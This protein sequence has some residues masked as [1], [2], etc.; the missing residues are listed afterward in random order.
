MKQIRTRL[1]YANVMSSI[2]V[3]LV[4]GGGAAFAATQLPANS[5]GTKQIKKNAVRT[6][7][8]SFEAIRAG[9]LSKN[10]VPTNRLRDK[11]VATEKIGDQAVT[12]GKIGDDAVTTG[13]IAA[14][15]VTTGKLGD[16]AVRAA[17][18]GPVTI[19]SNTTAVGTESTG[20]VTVS[21]EA[22]EKMIGGGGGF[23]IVTAAPHPQVIT[24]QSSNST[25][26]L[27]RAFNPSAAF[28]RTL[29]VQ[30]ICLNT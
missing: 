5:V 16:E 30:A 11:A 22:G 4:L 29:T 13:K 15:A 7:K 9:K 14:G 12:E 10:A 2:A 17:K 28:A 6:G 24:S 27:V 8:V 26:W 21:C 20:N 25:T 23:N 18:L 19:R 3:F 1:T